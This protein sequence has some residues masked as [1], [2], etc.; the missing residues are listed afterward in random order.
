[1]KLALK[2]QDYEISKLIESN[3]ECD[4]KRRENREQDIK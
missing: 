3:K 2:N 4:N 1:M